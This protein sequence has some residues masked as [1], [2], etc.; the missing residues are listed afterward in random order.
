MNKIQLKITG[1]ATTLLI[2]GLLIS[3]SINY[4][5][6]YG[7]TAFCLIPVLI[8][9]LP[10]FIA[11]GKHALTKKESYQLSFL[12]LILALL[13]LL[14][15]AF[16][17]MI[18]IAMVLPLAIPIVWLSSYIAFRINERRVFKVRDFFH[19]LPLLAILSMSF[20][21][22]NENKEHVAVETSVI[23]HAP[24]QSVWN[25]VT[26]FD[27]INQ[28]LD[29]YLKTGIAYPID[30]HIKGSGV[31]AVRY[32]NFSTGS[33]VEPITTWKEPT[34]LAFSVKE[35][36]IPMNEWNPFW[37]IHPPHLDGYFQSKKGQFSLTE[38]ANGDTKLSGTTWYQIDIAPA[39][40]WQ[41]W[42]NFLIHKIHKR[43]LHHIKTEAENETKI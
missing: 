32:C 3:I 33:F 11:G 27:T 35:Q 10:P 41:S 36:P 12:S 17:G 8:G 38:L 20:D 43:V 14:I 22:Y 23:I 4:F 18:C 26:H 39:T 29:W 19:V 15:F 25:Q 24:I 1:V 31:G 5:G 13:A 16:E 42:S 7:W 34:L 2:S 6:E 21:Y 40:Y 30:A 9:F 37:D 28:P